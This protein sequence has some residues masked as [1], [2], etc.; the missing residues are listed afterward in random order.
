MNPEARYTTDDS[1][2]ETLR[3]IRR[4]LGPVLAAAGLLAAA[5]CDSDPQGPDIPPP[6]YPYTQVGEIVLPGNIHSVSITPDGSTVLAISRGFS[7]A[8]FVVDFESEE[9]LA[10]LEMGDEPRGLAVTPDAGVA[11]VAS[12]IDGE[13]YIVDLG[14]FEVEDTVHVGGGP[15]NVNI[16]TSGD[17][18]YVSNWTERTIQ[19]VNLSTPGVTDTIGVTSAPFDV[20]FPD[21]SSYFF[22]SHPDTDQVS[23]I[24]IATGAVIQIL[25]VPDHPCGMASDPS[26]DA[27]FVMADTL[28]S[29]SVADLIIEDRLDIATPPSQQDPIDLLPDGSYLYLGQPFEVHIV[30]L[31]SFTLDY[32]VEDMSLESTGICCHPSG[33]YVLVASAGTNIAILGR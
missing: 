11:C 12:Y 7:D 6:T 33:E 29:I 21:G 22:V 16:S 30:E 8:L 2:T 13:V 19:V 28:V 15:I 23:V 14:S 9:V 31:A 17:E 20:C 3:R 26:G 24:D 32:I 4:Q 27:V 5:S 1:L 25:E 18:A 10:T